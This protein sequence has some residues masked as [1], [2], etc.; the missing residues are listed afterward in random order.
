MNLEGFTSINIWK[1]FFVS[2]GLSGY[3]AAL[4][5]NCALLVGGYLVSEK[6]IENPPPLFPVLNTTECVEPTE[7]LA[8]CGV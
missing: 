8:C 6:R 1:I 2:H 5:T 3:T 7:I 4:L